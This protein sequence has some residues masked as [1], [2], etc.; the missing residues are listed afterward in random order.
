MLTCE[1]LSA[2]VGGPLV[3]LEILYFGAIYRDSERPTSGQRALYR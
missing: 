3:L 1:F 2:A